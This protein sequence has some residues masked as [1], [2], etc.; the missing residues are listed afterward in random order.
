MRE[1]GIAVHQAFG[2]SLSSFALTHGLSS[3][4]HG[5]NYWEAKGWEPI[6]SGGL[7]TARYFHPG[8]RERLRVPEAIAI[9]QD[10]VE[11]TS[12][13]YANVCDC[14]VCRNVVG[15]E[16]ARFGRFGEV[17][18]KTRRTRGGGTAEFDSPT[19]EALYL[20][21]R[22]YLHAK[23]AEVALA[24]RKDFS[25]PAR[26]EADAAYWA[27]DITRTRHLDRWAIALSV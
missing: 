19:A 20:T 22:H 26:L 4:A 7:P 23:G 6:A 25:A 14:E 12:E 5:V 3:I 13:F 10:A 15:D 16:I 9:I 21:K 27:S 11:N 17:N 18:I 24:L 8:L 1:R 2:G